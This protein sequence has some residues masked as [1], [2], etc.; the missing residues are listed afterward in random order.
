V[1]VLHHDSVPEAA[2]HRAASKPAGQAGGKAG[3]DAAGASN[4]ALL[5]QHLRVDFE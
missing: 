4:C 5:C 1:V 2:D 3:A